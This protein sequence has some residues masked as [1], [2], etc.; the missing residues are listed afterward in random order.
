MSQ[1]QSPSQTQGIPATSVLPLNDLLDI[2]QNYLNDLGQLSNTNTNVAGNLSALQ[3]KLAQLKTSFE[4]ANT[5]SDK[6]LTHQSKIA[7]ILEKEN[8]RLSSIK[9]E[10]DNTHF[11]KMRTIHLNDNYRKRQSEYIKIIIVLLIGLLVYIGLSV[12]IPEPL[13]SFLVIVLFSVIFIYSANIVWEIYKRE[14]INYDRLD[15]KPP[16]NALTLERVSEFPPGAPVA[17][18]APATPASSG[19]CTG[20][21]CCSTGSRWDATMNRCIIAC[22]DPQLPISK[23]NVCVATSQCVSPFKMCGNACISESEACGPT[24]TNPFSTLGDERIKTKH[25]DSVQPYSPYE[26]DSYSRV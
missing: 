15:L 7:D 22:S 4:N 24:N 6:I 8:D 21:A 14:N 1:P 13:Y 26:Y 17:P 16:S 18:G 10:V 12:F 11:S 2:Q 5:S 19:I 20:E 9:N 25:E 23:G 3:A